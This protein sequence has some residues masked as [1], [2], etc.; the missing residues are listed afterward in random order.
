[1]AQSVAPARGEIV[2]LWVTDL[3]RLLSPE[4]VIE[5]LP[6]SL[7]SACRQPRGSGPLGR[8]HDRR[9]FLFM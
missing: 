6:R 2:L 8:L 1:M 3:R 7:C 5:A 4:V 9:R